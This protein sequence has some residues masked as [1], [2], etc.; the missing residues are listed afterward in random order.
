M[1]DVRSVDI[2]AEVSRSP[3]QQ[4]L[5]KYISFHLLHTLLLLIICSFTEMGQ[6]EHLVTLCYPLHVFPGN[7]F[8]TIIALCSM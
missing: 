5:I 7:V 8:D 4:N 6:D 3:N 1:E 2:K